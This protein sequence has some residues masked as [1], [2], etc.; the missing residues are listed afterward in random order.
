MISHDM[1]SVNSMNKKGMG[2]FIRKIIVKLR[3]MGMTT[4]HLHCDN[5]GENLEQMLALC[6]EF[7]MVLELTAPDS[8]QQNG[9]VERRFV[10]WKQ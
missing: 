10:V 5:A 7:A 8:S 9:V 2:M 4:K 1:D 3:A 6:E